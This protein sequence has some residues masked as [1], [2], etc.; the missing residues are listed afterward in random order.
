MTFAR[1]RSTV[2]VCAAALLL[3]PTA[4]ATADSVVNVDFEGGLG[5]D[6]NHVGSDGVMSTTGTV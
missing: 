2:V 4:A 5:L 3:G 1:L 6:V